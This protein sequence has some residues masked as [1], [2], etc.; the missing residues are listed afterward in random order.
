MSDA[1]TLFCTSAHSMLQTPWLYVSRGRSLKK[2][3]NKCEGKASG[4]AAL[5]IL[6][7]VAKLEGVGGAETRRN[8]QGNRCTWYCKTKGLD[9]KELKKDW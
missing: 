8:K 5:E 2:W 3:K 9:E 6:R 1:N 7:N 4:W